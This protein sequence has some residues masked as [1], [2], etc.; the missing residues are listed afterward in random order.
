M[1]PFT[2]YAIRAA[3]IVAE[4]EAAAAEK[5]RQLGQPEEWEPYERV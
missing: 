5:V 4:W 2:E 3:I 1:D